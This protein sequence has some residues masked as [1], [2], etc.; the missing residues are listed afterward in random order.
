MESWEDMT[1]LEE[2]MKQLRPP[3]PRRELKPL[4]RCVAPREIASGRSLLTVP[5]TKP[6]QWMDRAMSYL[7]QQWFHRHTRPLAPRITGPP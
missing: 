3:S 1:E 4:P 7:P 2:Q 5:A 6:C